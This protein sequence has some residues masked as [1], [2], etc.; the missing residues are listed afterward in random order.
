[1]RCLFFFFFLLKLFLSVCLSLRPRPF[2][3]HA[4]GFLASVSLRAPSAHIQRSTLVSP[5]FRPRS[6]T[7]SGWPAKQM[8]SIG[9]L[10]ELRPKI[11]STAWIAGIS[12]VSQI[13]L[14][15]TGHQDLWPSSLIRTILSASLKTSENLAFPGPIS[16]GEARS[17]L[18]RFEVVS[19]APVC[20]ISFTSH[21]AFVSPNN[22]VR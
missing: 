11:L 10:V 7:G 13:T 20:A 22:P 9:D 1:M 16:P 12:C 17:D 18:R 6:R 15:C 3:G 14:S 2:L 21:A 4:L 5:R 19:G 8:T